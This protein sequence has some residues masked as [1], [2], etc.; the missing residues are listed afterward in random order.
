MKEEKRIINAIQ[1]IIDMRNVQD[2]MIVFAEIDTKI[3]KG[4]IDLDSLKLSCKKELV[5]N[6]NEIE[7]LFNLVFFYHDRIKTLYL[8]KG[9]K[10]IVSKKEPKDLSLQE[11]EEVRN[12]DR[13]VCDNGVKEP[14]RRVLKEAQ[15]FPLYERIIN[16]KRI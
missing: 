11:I 7:T 9:F 5:G 13:T 12:L 3:E 6:E 15:L 8:L 16:F 4:I 1:N 2:S 10:V 14:F